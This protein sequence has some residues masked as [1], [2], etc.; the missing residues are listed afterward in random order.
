MNTKNNVPSYLQT[1][2]DVRDNDQYITS[3][4]RSWS[5]HV[6]F[7]DGEI[8]E[9]SSYRE[10]IAILFNSTEEDVIEIF[11][12]SP[13]GSLETTLAIVEGL[14]ATNASVTAILI[15]SCHSAASIITMYC[16]NIV[17]LDSASM[18]IHTA[19]FGTQGT[20]G[21][22]K[23]HTE[24]TVRMVEK[25]LNETYEGFLTSDELEKIKQGVEIW[26]D[27]EDMRK[28]MKKRAKFLE[29]LKKKIEKVRK[30]VD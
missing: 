7:L 17:V 2:M 25:V 18:M 5:Q 26:V 19:S 9:P 30:V 15:G 28:R 10:L 24:F 27:A 22:V 1:L 29:N 12:N 16:Q 6:V 23:S 20:T 3:T 11:I 4:E 13:G 14:K 8:L 21:N